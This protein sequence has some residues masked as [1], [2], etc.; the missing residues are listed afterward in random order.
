MKFA[1]KLIHGGQVHLCYTDY[2]YSEHWRKK[3]KK[4]YKR[5]K[6]KETL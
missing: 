3:K 5:K 4:K 2:V 1:S 6:K